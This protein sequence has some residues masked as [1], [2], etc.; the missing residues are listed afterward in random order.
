MKPWLEQFANKS[1][2]QQAAEQSDSPYMNRLRGLPEAKQEFTLAAVLEDLAGRTGLKNP[3]SIKA[4]SRYRHVLLKKAMK[5]VDIDVQKARIEEEAIRLLKN[6]SPID[7]VNNTISDQV[8]KLD[9]DLEQKKEVMQHF[10][11]L[12]KTL[13]DEI[14]SRYPAPGSSGREYDRSDASSFISTE[15]SFPGSSASGGVR[16]SPRQVVASILLSARSVSAK[17]K[18]EPKPEASPDASPAFSGLVP[19]SVKSRDLFPQ[20]NKEDFPGSFSEFKSTIAQMQK[21]QGDLFAVMVQKEFD[22]L[23]AARPENDKSSVGVLQDK[24]YRKVFERMGDKLALNDAQPNLYEVRCTFM[25]PDPENDGYLKM[26]NEHFYEEMPIN[27]IAEHLLFDTPR[28][29]EVP[30]PSGRT[31][32]SKPGFVQGYGL[33]EIRFNTIPR[34][35]AEAFEDYWFSRSFDTG[36]TRK[37][38]AYAD[39]KDLSRKSRE[40]ELRDI[41]SRGRSTFLRPQKYNGATGKYEDIPSED[42]KQVQWESMTL[43]PADQDTIVLNDDKLEAELIKYLGAGGIHVSSVITDDPKFA[44]DAV[45]VLREEL[46][47]KGDAPSYEVNWLEL[48]EVADRIWGYLNN[49]RG[50]GNSIDLSRMPRKKKLPAKH[51]WKQQTQSTSVNIEAA[52]DDERDLHNEPQYERPKTGSWELSGWKCERCN[53]AETETLKFAS[54]TAYYSFACP[55]CEEHIVLHKGWDCGQCGSHNMATLNEEPEGIQ[56]GVRR[57]EVRCKAVVDFHGEMLPTK[58][59]TTLDP[60]RAAKIARLFAELAKVD[61]HGIAIT[62]KKTIKQ[63]RLAAPKYDKSEY[64]EVGRAINHYQGILDQVNSLTISKQ[65]DFLAAEEWDEIEAE[66]DKVREELLAAGDAQQSLYSERDYHICGHKQYITIRRFKPRGDLTDSISEG[67]G[68]FNMTKDQREQAE[69]LRDS[70]GKLALEEQ[71]VVVVPEEGQSAIKSVPKKNPL[72]DD[73]VPDEIKDQVDNSKFL[74][75]QILRDRR[76]KRAEI[77]R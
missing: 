22:E 21:K 4:R 1:L 36:R 77:F 15:Q 12:L 9:I 11:N 17:K 48:R 45:A 75:G 66:L 23:K 52:P 27:H 47:I 56:Y 64:A 76:A 59:A 35:D 49:H 19:A 68:N 3:H 26:C 24:A 63:L 16:I 51:K 60:D 18:D 61:G 58:D 40:R 46:G 29:F 7:L 53:Y 32:V 73:N 71:D 28:D 37:A 2:T 31:G 74:E 41:L 72:D 20:L 33:N 55:E 54:D 34:E 13:P 67:L 65:V 42:R 69:A 50:K 57:Y 30:L 62:W 8:F 14:A 39:G 70:A 38:G 43:A 10:S 5:K 44:K 6:G 25:I